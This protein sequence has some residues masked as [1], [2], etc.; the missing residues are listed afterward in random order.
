MVAT[1][2]DAEQSELAALLNHH[3]VTVSCGERGIYPIPIEV[4]ILMRLLR[5]QMQQP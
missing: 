3:W 4:A 2:P 1:T 5:K